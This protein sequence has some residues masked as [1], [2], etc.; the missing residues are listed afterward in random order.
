PR[1]LLAAV[2]VEPVLSFHTRLSLIK[3]LPAETG[4]SYGLTFRL[5]RETRV[6]ILAAGYGDGI[7][8]ALSN[9]GHA[10]LRGRKCPILGRVTMDQTVVDL[11]TVP[12]AA[13]G[14]VAT[15]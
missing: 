10:I 9:V 14:D 11:S 13:P 1:S 8:T 6:G 7:P 5:E 15:L 4:I 12:D 3:S 2:D